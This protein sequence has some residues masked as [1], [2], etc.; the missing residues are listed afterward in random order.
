MSG[1]FFA[2]VARALITHICGEA[3][4][5]MMEDLAPDLPHPLCIAIGLLLGVLLV[6]ITERFWR[7]R[8]GPHDML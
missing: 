8:G 6:E 5:R 4:R 1:P 3:L 2:A 7:C